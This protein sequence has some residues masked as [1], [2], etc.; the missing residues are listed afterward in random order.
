MV[1]ETTTTKT[2]V[3]TKKS[4]DSIDSVIKP[5]PRKRRQSTV[6]SQSAELQADN[7]D[8][9]L[10]IAVIAYYKAESRGFEPGYELQDWLEAEAETAAEAEGG[11]VQ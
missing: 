2:T 1:L 11:I 3:K 5:S 9:L 10:R 4:K 7:Q 8:K 6:P